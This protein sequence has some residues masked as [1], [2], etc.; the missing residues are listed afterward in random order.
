MGVAATFRLFDVGAGADKP[1]WKADWRKFLQRFN[2]LQFVGTLDFVSS[3][4]LREGAYGSMLM[5]EAAG[6]GTAEPGSPDELEYLLQFVDLSLRDFVRAV[7]RAGKELP[8]AGFEL[9]GK[10]GEI[11]ATAELA[12]AGVKIAVLLEHEWELRLNFEQSG[13]T[14]RD[15]AFAE[16]LIEQLPG[17]KN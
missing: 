8:E 3:S 17:A 13:W 9:A 11:V 10:D 5:P 7:A 16:E 12:W 6:P 1:K 2:V 14:V 4:G 15:A